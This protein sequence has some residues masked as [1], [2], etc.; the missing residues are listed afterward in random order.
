[1]I[2]DLRNCNH[3]LPDAVKTCSGGFLGNDYILH[4]LSNAYHAESTI[5]VGNL[6]N[7]Y[8]SIEAWFQNSG[9]QNACYLA[10][11]GD[12]NNRRMTALPVSHEWRKLTIRGI[13]VKSGKCT[14]TLFSDANPGNWCKLCNVRLIKDDKP[15]EFLKG[16]DVSELLRVEDHGGKY[17]YKGEERDC[18]EILKEAGFNIVRIRLYND[19][20]NPE[21]SPSNRLNPHGY[22]NPA[23]TLE[24]AR[25]AKQHGF[26]ILLSF[27]YSDYWTNG[28]SQFK[29]H[30]WENLEFKSLVKALYDFTYDFM[31]KMLEQD[32]LPEYVSIGNEIQGGICYPEG[33]VSNW[34]QLAELLN[35][36]HDAVKAVSPS[37]RVILHL[38][39]ATDYN[40]YE[41]FFGN[42]EFYNVRYDII[43]T[44]YYPFWSQKC[45]EDLRIF[46]DYVSARFGKDNIVME[47]GYNW[48]PSASDGLPG[49]HENNGPV[50]YPSTPEGQK[51]FMLELFNAIKCVRG[52]RCIGDIYWDPIMI[53]V[54]GLGW[55]EGK[56]N[57]VDNTTLFD[58][59]GEALPVLDVYKYNT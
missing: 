8:Y 5:T 32:T 24:L 48:N 30:E 53:A 12:D 35:A 15:F 9:G 39:G 13:P 43:G 42:C 51:N 45:V 40:K 38:D 36:G 44:S 46:C 6:D 33:S 57:V 55:E 3:S 59:K 2:I 18:L 17:Y 27:H 52:G 54:P 19:P 11:G 29:P 50:Q 37:S 22:Q 1:M 21:F 23:H 14:I 49:Q 26:Q 47:I 31:K 16:G 7:G 41:N 28:L 58:F 20:G 4:S 10:A 25:R 56:R 34:P